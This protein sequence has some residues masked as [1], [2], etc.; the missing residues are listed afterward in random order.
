MDRRELLGM[1]GAAAGVLAVGAVEGR[2]AD[3]CAAPAPGQTH[4]EC[5]KACGECAKICN[6]SAHHC[7][8]RLSA[9]EGLLKHHAKALHTGPGLRVVLRPLRG[10]D[11]PLQ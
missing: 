6:M 4:E 2:A 1:F 9:G 10:D 3:D 11:R 7:A 8:E 5:L